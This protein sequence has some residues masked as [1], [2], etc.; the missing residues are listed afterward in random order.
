MW[1]PHWQTS[2]TPLRRGPTNTTAINPMH[3]EFPNSRPRGNWGSVSGADSFW[4]PERWYFDLTEALA[5]GVPLAHRT[6]C[7]HAGLWAT[8]PSALSSLGEISP[9][10]LIGSEP[11]WDHP[12]QQ[13]SHFRLHAG[14]LPRGLHSKAAWLSLPGAPS[15]SQPEECYGLSEEAP[16]RLRMGTILTHKQIT[17]PKGGCGHVLPDERDSGWWI[18]QNS[19]IRQQGPCPRVTASLRN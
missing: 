4:I 7:A 8:F 11:R 18:T 2:I 16:R 15:G 9:S 6:G 10:W 17:N 5:R 1:D 13:Q 14:F 19:R 3:Q 12:D